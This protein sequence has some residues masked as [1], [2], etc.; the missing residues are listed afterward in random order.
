MCLFGAFW[1]PF[2]C[3]LVALGTPLGDFGSTLAALGVAF[4]TFLEDLQ[5][6]CRVSGEIFQMLCQ[7][8]GSVYDF[9]VIFQ[10]GLQKIGYDGI[11]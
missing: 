1:L 3:F 8:Y 6:L 5:G 2:G 7:F 4:E 10:P 9:L 11:W